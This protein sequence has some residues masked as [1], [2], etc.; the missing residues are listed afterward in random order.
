ML[1]IFGSNQEKEKLYTTY[2]FYILLI[3]LCRLNQ[4]LCTQVCKGLSISIANVEKKRCD[5]KNSFQNKK[6]LL[7]D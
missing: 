1:V 7:L 6:I 5:L 2:C 3:F 4:I